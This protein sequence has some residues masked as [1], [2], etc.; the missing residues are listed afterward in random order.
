MLDLNILI[1]EI[2]QLET[3]TVISGVSLA[4]ALS[5]LSIALL[6]QLK[7]K[8]NVRVHPQKKTELQVDPNLVTPIGKNF[9]WDQEKPL[10]FRPYRDGD[11]KMSMAL[12]KINKNDWILIDDKYKKYSDLRAEIFDKYTKEL[13]YCNKN[14]KDDLI[15]FYDEVFQFLINRYP[16]YFIESDDGKTILNT[17][18]NYRLPIDCKKLTII[19]ILRILSININEDFVILCWDEKSEE[20]VLR[21]NSTCFAA[22]FIPTENVNKPLTKIHKPVPGYKENLKFPMSKFF[23]RIT[24]KDFYYRVNWF[25]MPFL[26]LCYLADDEKYPENLKTFY[27]DS[28]ENPINSETGEIDHSK[29]DYNKIFIRSERQ[30]LTKLP[31][32]K[33]VVMVVRTYCYPLTQIRKEEEINDKLIGAI[34][35]IK[36]D[37][38]IYKGKEGWQNLVLPYLK[39]EVNGLT[40][41]IIEYDFDR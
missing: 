8:K 36:G 40:D 2:S 11:Y 39:G 35:G 24:S 14:Y 41:E 1:T 38:A 3:N 32:S 5:C 29:I 33:S 25:V 17:I 4:V 21:C 20:Y 30:T 10:V 27:K 19:E 31:K 7:L 12:N 13:V 15:E 26:N 22:G 34:N 9:K 18:L 28:G 37:L 6:R 23:N 16:N